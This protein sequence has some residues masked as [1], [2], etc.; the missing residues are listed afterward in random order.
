MTEQSTQS[1]Q[2]MLGATLV[3][4]SAA[5]FGLAGA[6]TKSIHADALTVTC[7]RG[8]VG[9]L[10]ITSYVLWRR[11]STGESLRLGWRGWLVAFV[12]A[13]A[14]IAFISAFKNGFVANVAIIYATVPFAA[15]V[16]SWLM[17]GEH[18]RA[19]TMIAAFVALAGVGIMVSIGLAG[20]AMLG[21][22][23]AVLMTLLSALYM[24]L[25]RKFTD[26]PLVWAGAVSA[27]L[28]FP[29]G[30]LVTDP[31]AISRHDAL[32]LLVFGTSFAIA[33]ILWT[34]GAR[35]IPASEAGLIGSAEVPFAILFAW[36]IL[37]ELPPAASLIGGAVVL[38]AVFAHA[39]LDW[40]RAHRAGTAR[41][42][43]TTIV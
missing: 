36:L 40:H 20:G 31:T 23:L 9:G 29:L 35:L 25:L 2:R 19:Q 17:L 11:R 16:L 26:T 37:S 33:V 42:R 5:V 34:E 27:F 41:R 43:P 6:L 8:L 24:V 14:S 38:G 30:W 4:A 18:V 1:A 10:I 12:G 13:A 39:G 3:G 15:A 21:N 32:M 22:A 7:W 28:L